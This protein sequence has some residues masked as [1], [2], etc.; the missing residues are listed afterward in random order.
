M[1]H[2]KKG[3]TFGR[4]RN[5]YRALLATLA[6]QLI[7]RGRL[8]TSE[9]KAKE[10]RPMVEKLITRA[11]RGALADRRELARRVPAA[12]AAKL[13]RD[14]APAM[15]RRLGGYTRIVRIGPRKSDASRMAIIEFVQ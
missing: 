11:K 12:A 3:R 2:L 7:A 13:V 14:V 8:R 9:A 4:S 5:Q 6:S 10:L 15:R 1:R